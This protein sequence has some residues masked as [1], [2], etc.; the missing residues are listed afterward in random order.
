MH[1]MSIAMSI[2]DIAREYAQKEKS[3]KVLEIELSIG[4]QA[5]IEFPALDFALANCIK[6]DVF[7]ET[8][9]VIHKIP[10]I[11]LCNNCDTEFEV[12]NLYDNCPGCDSYNTDVIKGKELKIK[13]ILIE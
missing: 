9:F 1:E 13:S 6:D 12:I 2:F 4:T 11:A 8:S 3:G 10:A 5:G 7:R